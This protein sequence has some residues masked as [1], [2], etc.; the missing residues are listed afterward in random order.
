MHWILFKS[1]RASKIIMWIK[2]RRIS[3]ALIAEYRPS[4]QAAQPAATAQW[5]RNRYQ[6]LFLK[7][8]VSPLWIP[9]QCPL[10]HP[11]G[12]DALPL[13]R[14]A[15]SRTQGRT[16]R[17]PSRAT[18]ALWMQITEL[19][20]IPITVVWMHRVV[21]RWGPQ[22]VFQ[23]TPR[24]PRGRTSLATIVGNSSLHQSFE[25]VDHKLR[26]SLFTAYTSFSLEISWLWSPCSRQVFP[27]TALFPNQI[28]VLFVFKLIDIS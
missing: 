18:P 26:F 10:R 16:S 23:A 4:R 27:I 8:A 5:T 15:N 2:H 22:C 19:P 11:S 25:K 7:A 6:L 13:H 24:I 21:H 9:L 20:L 12:A 1:Y 3:E 28:C 17:S 14:L